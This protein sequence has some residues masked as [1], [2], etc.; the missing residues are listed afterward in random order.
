[1]P[2]EV[3]CAAVVPLCWAKTGLVL[4]FC[5]NIVD[6][7]SC[8]FGMV[9]ILMEAVFPVVL[10]LAGICGLCGSAQMS[11]PKDLVAIAGPVKCQCVG[12]FTV[13]SIKPNI[14]FSA[15]VWSNMLFMAQLNFVILIMS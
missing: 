6:G 5:S 11:P 14:W 1:M 13:C 12:F 7:T 4:F 3:G 2:G 8:T 10:L 15:S 9:T